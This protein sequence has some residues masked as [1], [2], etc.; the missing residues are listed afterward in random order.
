MGN[1]NEEK[2]IRT[3]DMSRLIN[4][5]LSYEKINTDASASNLAEFLIHQNEYVESI[6]EKKDFNREKENA[7]NKLID[8]IAMYIHDENDIEQ[9]RNMNML[10]R[11]IKRK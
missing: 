8:R 10:I 3:H 9:I 7:Y 4:Q 2:N 11:R 5:H 1:I 6:N